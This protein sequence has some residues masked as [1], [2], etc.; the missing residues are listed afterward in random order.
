[1]MTSPS[2][3]SLRAI[4]YERYCVGLIALLIKLRVTLDQTCEV[5]AS[6][7]VRIEFVFCL[8]SVNANKTSRAFFQHLGAHFCHLGTFFSIWVPG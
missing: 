6:V 8:S 1:M 3:R 5:N 7:I 4:N 2:T